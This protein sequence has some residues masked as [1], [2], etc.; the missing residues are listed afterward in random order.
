MI[1][2]GELGRICKEAVMPYICTSKSGETEE[3]HE[4]LHSG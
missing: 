3:I 2:N 1:A 4:N